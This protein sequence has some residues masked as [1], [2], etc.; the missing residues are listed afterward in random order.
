MYV[1]RN[2]YIF[3]ELMKRHYESEREQGGLYQKIRW[4]KG[5]NYIIIISY[6]KT[7]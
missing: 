1:F 7:K 6:N 2:I 3:Q 4:R 5:R